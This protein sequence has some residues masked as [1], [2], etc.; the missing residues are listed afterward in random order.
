[1]TWAFIPNVNIIHNK[2]PLPDPPI[3]GTIRHYASSE[4]ADRYFCGDCGAVIF[5]VS[6]MRPELLNV[7][8]GVL[9]DELGA[10]A[11]G[12]LRWKTSEGPAN[13]ADGLRRGFLT[14]DLAK[15]MIAWGS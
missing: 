9:Y 13:A 3:F 7:A 14:E 4:D 12:W 10:R 1:M 5:L 6:K 2:K 11:E 15:Q 8:V